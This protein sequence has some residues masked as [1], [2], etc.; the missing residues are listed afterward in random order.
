LPK[1][2]VPFAYDLK[3][4]PY[5][6]EESQYEEK[7]FTFEGSIKMHFNCSIQTNK[8]IFH[9][10]GLQIDPTSLQLASSAKND[11]TKVDQSFVYDQLRGYYTVDLNKECVA[12]RD[13]TLSM[14]FKGEILTILLGF[15]RSSYT[16]VNGQKK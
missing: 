2:L 11:D 5:I 1:N 3:I 6:G 8:I 9:G 12:Q 16:D 10:V 7:A 14:K 4:R 15:Y 13:Y